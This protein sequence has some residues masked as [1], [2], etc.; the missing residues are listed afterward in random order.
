MRPQLR[1]SPVGGRFLAQSQQI[2][3]RHNGLRQEATSRL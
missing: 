2:G 3:V 1:E